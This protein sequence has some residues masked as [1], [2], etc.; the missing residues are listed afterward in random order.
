MFY[1]QQKSSKTSPFFINNP[2]FFQNLST[3]NYLVLNKNN[4]SYSDQYQLKGAIIQD[5]FFKIKE[6]QMLEISLDAIKSSFL[7]SLINICIL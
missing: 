1:C 7:A 2:E 6:K 4:I 5:H 3:A